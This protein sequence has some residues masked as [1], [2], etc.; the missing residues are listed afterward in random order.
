[1]TM[2]DAPALGIGDPVWIRRSA[3]H[4]TKPGEFIYTARPGVIVDRL[5]HC[6]KVRE[7][8]SVEAMQ[9]GKHD[10]RTLAAFIDCWRR[11]ADV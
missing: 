6:W 3:E 8:Q 10:R 4:P 5:G 11:E 1:M 7:W 9:D 2:T